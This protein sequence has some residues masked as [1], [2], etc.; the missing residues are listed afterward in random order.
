MN[1]CPIWVFGDIMLDHYIFGTSTRMSPEAPVPVLTPRNETLKLGGACNVAMN[2]SSF[3]QNVHLF[4]LMGSDKA[5]YDIRELLHSARINDCCLSDQ[6]LSTIVKKRYIANGQQILRVDTDCKL[7]SKSS[8]LM[9]KALQ[10]YAGQRIVISDYLK[11]TVPDTRALIDMAHT[12][13]QLVLVDPKGTSWERYFGADIVTPNRSE[14]ALAMNCSESDLIPAAQAACNKFNLGHIVLTRSED[15]ICVVNKQGLVY[16]TGS[17]AEQVFDV[18]GAG[19]IVISCLARKLSTNL[20][21]LIPAVNFANDAASF[22]VGKLGTVQDIGL[23]FRPN[24][25]EKIIDLPQLKEITSKN[26]NKKFIFTNGCFDILHVGHV[27][28]LEQAKRHGDYLVVAINSD[29]SV[30]RIKGNNRPI[31]NLK[32]RANQVAALTAVDFVI[33]FNEDTPAELYQDADIKYLAKGA[34]YELDQ[35]IGH[36]VVS[37]NHGKVYRIKLNNGFSSTSIISKI[38]STK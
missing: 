13:D 2:L 8:E 9:D 22:S 33:T 3:D 38:R 31:H 20:S 10:Q 28:Y 32:F 5:S 24:H 29:T 23:A 6:S 19:D 36:E 35:I 26:T 7:H 1:S 15:G 27:N 18:T 16:E 21:D 14:L 37:R 17:P 12:H 25:P 11:G 34:D 30:K 4:G